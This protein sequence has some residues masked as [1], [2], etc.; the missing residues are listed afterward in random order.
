MGVSIETGGGGGRKSLNADLNLVPFIDL[1]SCC[2]SF[3]LIS[4]VWT[5]VN[6]I[7]V[8]EKKAGKS[9]AA[10]QNLDKPPEKLVVIVDNDLGYK[11]IKGNDIQSIPKKGTDY[12]VQGLANFLK[13]VRQAFPPERKDVQVA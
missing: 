7:T 9:S 2:I 12:D 3:L 8:N 11:V 5:Q 6:R 4:A 1:M 13:G 10:M